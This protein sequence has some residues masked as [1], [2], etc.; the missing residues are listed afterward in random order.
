[1]DTE[2]MNAHQAIKFLIPVAVAGV[3]FLMSPPSGLSVPA[4]HLAGI[5]VATIV[6]LMVQTLPEAAV[7]IIAVAAAGLFAVP[8]KEVLAGYTDSTLWLIVTA[9]MVSLGLKKTGL[10]RRIGLWLIASFGKTSLRIAYVLGFLDLLLATSTPAAPAR[11]GGIVYPLAEGVLEASGTAD[12]A[13]PRELGAYLTVLG[14]MMCLTTGSIFLTGLAPNLY[15]VKLAKDILG[16]TVDWPTWTLAALPNFVGFLLT[17]WLVFKVYPPGITSLES[18]RE[19]VSDKRKAQG[20]VTTQEILSACVFLLIVGLWATGTWN[21]LD[22]TLVAFIG[23]SLMLILGIVTWKDIAEAKEAWAILVWFGAILGLSAALG[24]QG[25]F[26]WFAAFIKSN[27]P[28]EGLS[29]FSI[30]VIIAVLAVLPHYLFASLVGYVAAMAPLFFAFVAA[31]D[32]PRYPAFFL[33]AYL[34]VIS[35]IL[36]HY[37]NGLGPLLMAKGYNDKRAWWAIGLML[38]VMHMVLYLT[39]GLAWWKLIGLWK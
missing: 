17:P 1:M 13:K 20:P 24:E 8:L 38:T 32:A 39:L 23:V 19:S 25:F 15:S 36:T 35:S 11:G 5:F 34:M 6:A 3:F 22:P 30:F 16:I 18:I 9:I 7:L 26:A 12:T 14:Y 29:T 37:G 27:L 28:T 33:V 10:T 31:T 4:W 21:K 2:K